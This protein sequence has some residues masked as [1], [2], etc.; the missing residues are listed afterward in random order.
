MYKYCDCR[1]SKGVVNTSK[2]ALGRG[3]MQITETT[4]RDRDWET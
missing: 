4:D 3:K 1:D 2:A